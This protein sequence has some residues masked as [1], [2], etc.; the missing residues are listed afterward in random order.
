MHRVDYSA[1]KGSVT[2]VT[3]LDSLRNEHHLEAKAVIL[4]AH[5]V[6]TPRLLLLSANGTFADGLA[7]SSGMVGKNFMSHPTWQLFGTFDRP[8]NAYK[9]MPM[10]HVMVQDFYAPSANADYARGFILLSYM[11]TPVTYG[12]LSGLSVGH[13]CKDLLHDYAYTAAWWA[14]AEG[15]PD[16][17]NTITLDSELRD[18]RDLPVARSDYEWGENDVNL[19]A[20]ARD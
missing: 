14:H 16:E 19:A 3:Y 7:N 10:G 1:A 15:L 17:R 13:E 5:A 8:V 18:A 20:A 2:G 9:G 12:I 11:M 6:E 4:A